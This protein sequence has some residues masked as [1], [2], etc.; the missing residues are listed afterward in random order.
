MRFVM[1]NGGDEEI[2]SASKLGTFSWAH[3]AVSIGDDAV[4]LYINGEEV[5]KSTNMTIRPSD[6]K[7]VMNYIGRSQFSSDPM[8][9]AYIDD[10]RV[11]NYAL[12]QEEI[13][14]ITE[15]LA[16]GIESVTN[17]V[18]PVIAT[19]YYSTNGTRLSAPQKGINIVKTRHADG[20]VSIKK[21]IK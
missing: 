5:A 20:K 16:N 18:A 3:I 4:T 8:I 12:S 11:Y 21:V 6:I 10:F 1:K 19:E 14:S 2:L 9:K 13:M 17:V 7:P 15:D